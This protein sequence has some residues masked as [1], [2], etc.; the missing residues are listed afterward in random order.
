MTRLA[1]DKFML[2]F[3]DAPM[4]D[5]VV[6]FDAK[7]RLGSMLCSAPWAPEVKT[8]RDVPR[9]RGGGTAPSAVKLSDTL[10]MIVDNVWYIFNWLGEPDVQVIKEHDWTA[11]LRGG[12]SLLVDISGDKLKFGKPR[13]ITSLHYPAVS[14]YD[15]PIVIDENTVLCPIDYDSN[16]TQLQDRP[17]ETVIMRTEDQGLTWKQ[18]GVI[19]L[20]KD[21][22]DLPK[23]LSPSVR[24][25]SSD[26]MVCA[27]QSHE[28]VPHIYMFTSEDCGVHWSAPWKSGIDGYNH[29][30]LP[31]SDGRLMITYSTAQEPSVMYR[32]SEDGGRTWPESTATVIE[33]ESLSL[34]SG[35]ARSLQLD[36]GSVFVVYYSHRQDE[37]RVIM[38]AHT[39]V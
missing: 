5:P 31:L 29:S 24:L 7:G 36:D 14:C 8:K 30:L 26:Y 2:L 1:A 22:P 11:I 34:D 20:E 15:S 37:M 25:I 17:W 35:R 27:M 18:H 16:C 39:E 10:A 33:N 23:M 6:R 32:I 9:F 4:R 3:H 38:G 21:N 28:L 13:R 19:I 12:F